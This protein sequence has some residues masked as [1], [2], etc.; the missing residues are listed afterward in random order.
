MA[1]WLEANE[2]IANQRLQ[3]AISDLNAKETVQNGFSF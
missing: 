3:G 2:R 1:G